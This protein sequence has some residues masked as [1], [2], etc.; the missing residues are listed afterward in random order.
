M[1]SDLTSFS[2]PSRRAGALQE[3]LI[4]TVAEKAF[5]RD[6][7][8]ALWFG[9]G[10]WPTSERAVTAAQ[11]ALD[12][13]DHFYHP[14]HGIPEFRDAIAHYQSQLYG[15]HLSRRHIT[16]TASGMQA[17]ALTAQALIDP[18]DRVLCITP[19][20]PN[21][22]EVFKI[23]GAE[24]EALALEMCDGRWHLDLDRLFDRLKQDCKI[25]LL[26][27]PNNPTGWVMNDKACAEVMAFCRS[28]GIWVVADE[29]YARLCRGRTVAPSFQNHAD[30]EDRLVSVNSFSKA[31][32]MTGWR[33][34]WITAPAELQPIYGALTEFN[35]ASAAG[36][37]QRAGQAMLETGEDEVKSLQTK[38]ATA[39]EVVSR[40]LRQ[41]DGVDFADPDGA[42]YIL[43]SIDGQTDSLK[44][45]Q[46]LVQDFGLGLA[47]GAAF[48][49][50]AE[51]HLRLCYAQEAGYLN[52]ACDRLE[53]AL[54]HFR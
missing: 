28:R 48:G 46:R 3:S 34:G 25:L 38:L 2:P 5:G 22:P 41:M 19:V 23:S 39:Y 47:P 20:W 49:A 14:N 7:V 52:R 50:S 35:I 24:V 31:W 53:A 43:F 15:R 27:S 4:R 33:L 9:E 30:P 6:D 12:A 37:I 51:G 44:L 26:N 32:S 54:K 45:A 40:R 13:G 10:R 17:L 1:T 18:G 42:F 8:L 16:V 29:V 11:A 36:F 21:L